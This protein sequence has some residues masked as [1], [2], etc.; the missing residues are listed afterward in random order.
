MLMLDMHD[1]ENLLDNSINFLEY[2]QYKLIIRPHPSRVHEVRN[3]LGKNFN[4]NIVID[5]EMNLTKSIKL[6]KP[7][8][9]LIG[10]SGVAAELILNKLNVALILN[11]NLQNYSPVLFFQNIK[12]FY[13]NKNINR[14]LN[15]FIKVTN[16]K[17]YSNKLHAEVKKIININ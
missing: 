8:L 5:L 13:F 9:F 10:Q 2:Q 7:V 14:D 17:S 4:T 3:Y 16:F 12:K 1:W 15:K 6:Y 11:S